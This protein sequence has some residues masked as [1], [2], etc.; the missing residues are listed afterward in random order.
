MKQSIIS[1]FLLQFVLLCF[2]FADNLVLR[3]RIK[4]QCQIIENQFQ[5]LQS[6]Q[7]TNNR[8]NSLLKDSITQSITLTSYY[9]QNPKTASGLKPTPGTVAVSRD[10]FRDGWT[11]G[12]KVYIP[13]Y[14]IYVI[15]DLTH[16]R[17]EQ[18]VDVLNFDKSKSIFAKNVQVTLLEDCN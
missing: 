14:G 6:L 4:S 5:V 1:I 9:P 18:R 13:Q 12:K 16:Q 8:L 15:Q 11:F 2:L 10:L 3:N 7:Q 17:L